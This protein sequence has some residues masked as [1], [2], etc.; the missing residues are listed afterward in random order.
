[1]HRLSILCH[2]VCV[3]QHGVRID[4]HLS[5]SSQLI[6][7]PAVQLEWGVQA[8]CSV[9]AVQWLT[10]C[11]V[12]CSTVLCP[13]CVS[14][15]VLSLLR[16]TPGD[17]ILAQRDATSLLVVRNVTQLRSRSVSSSPPWPVVFRPL[18]QMT[19]V[20]HSTLDTQHPTLSTQLCSVLLP[21]PFSPF[22]HR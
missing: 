21:F 5:V 12:S 4:Q 18:Q 10:E 11:C 15:H 6:H 13:L 1:M 20:H 9:S 14:K 16:R 3:C 7:S 17:S 19:L 2:P 22:M 8:V